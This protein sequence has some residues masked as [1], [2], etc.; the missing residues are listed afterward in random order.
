MLNRCSLAAAAIAAALSGP[1]LAAD[2]P[3][4]R[5]AVPPPV[6]APE[7]TCPTVA[8]QRQT[9]AVSLPGQTAYIVASSCRV[10]VRQ[11]RLSLLGKPSH[12]GISVYY[13]GGSMFRP[14]VYLLVVPRHYV[15]PA[16]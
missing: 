10:D 5:M 4:A 13:N 15:A 3:E 11:N 12:V 14:D 7:A 8:Y 1:A 2:M 9:N 16:H 6:Y